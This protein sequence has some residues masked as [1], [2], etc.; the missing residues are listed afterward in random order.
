MLQESRS[1]LNKGGYLL[2]PVLGLARAEEIL[3][4]ARRAYGERI[5]K[6][7][8]KWIPFC[9]ELKENLDVLNRLRN[10]GII[11]FITKQSRHL[12]NLGIY[13]ADV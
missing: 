12:W 13:R 8:E 9:D 5:R 2:F 11:Q 1:H 7:T 3:A 4:A 6:V 10:E